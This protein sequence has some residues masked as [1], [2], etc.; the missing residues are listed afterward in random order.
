MYNWEAGVPK[1]GATVESNGINFAIFAKN[2]KKV[3]LNI[4]K[5]GSDLLP[6]EKIV[7]DPSINKTGDIW[8]IFLQNG[9]E[10]TLYTW[11][12]DDYPEILDPYAL[13]YT[14]NKNYS[15]RKSIAI[16]LSHEKEKHLEIPMQDTIIYEVHI[17]LFTQNFNSM[18]EFP[19][20]YSG[21]LEKIPYLK[22]LGITAVE[23]LP[24]YEWDDFTGN[25]GINNGAKLK[26]IWGYNP[27]GFFALTK[28]FS[29]N[30]KLDSHSEIVEF[31]ELVKELHKNGIEVILDVVYNHT[32]EGG[33]GG[34]FYN[35]K[36]MDLNTFYMLENSNV[37]FMNYSGC[38]NTVNTN[39]KVVKDM[40]VSSLRYWYLEMGVDGFRFDLA[41]ILGRNEE[42]HW[43]GENSLLNELVQ[44]PILSHCKLIS[45][46]WDL[47]GYYVG[48]MPIGW[49]EW[50]GKYRDV[51]KKFIKGEFGQVSELLKRIFGSPDIFKRNDRTPYS[52]INFI[53]CHDG[54]TMWDLVSYNNKHNLNNGENNQDGENHNNSYN[55]G[56]EGET[57]D[58]NIIAIRKQQLKNMLLILFISQGVPMILMGDEMGR[59]QLGNNNAYCQNNR[60]TWIDW[61]RGSNFSDITEFTKNM[62]KLRKKYNIFRN[63]DYLELEDNKNKGVG[64]HGVK[65][66]CPDFSYYS[67]SIAF[68]L[69]DANSDTTFYIIL[70]SYHGDLNF[71]LPKL[72]SKK[73]HLLVDTSKDDSENFLEDGKLISDA[74]YKAAPKSS[75]ILISK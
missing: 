41:S 57:E 61:E 53:T 59:T 4:Y 21:F 7:L 11:K 6:K 13:S 55:N 46:S 54:F 30:Q 60:S 74:F 25:I 16:K 66:N 75:V 64:I 43:L 44:D 67:L 20:T 58:K 9:S 34:K 10:G 3:V 19:G 31:K 68:S 73:W 65:L 49:S 26:N 28:K 36:A 70:N 62:I 45:E 15:N 5:S 35:F 24:V 27:I 47:G 50:N 52:N 22:E 71:E 2:K 32:A 40:I 51:V 18:V 69:Y 1:L 42:G 14:N 72:D 17:K 33:K 56:A 48:D 23:F 12:I 37:Q 8:H 63:K 38:G 39:N 29:K